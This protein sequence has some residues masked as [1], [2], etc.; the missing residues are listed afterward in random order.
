M[1]KKTERNIAII[2]ILTGL[3]LQIVT[4]ISGFIIPKIILK[5]FGSEANGLISSLNQILNF[6]TL[7][8]GGMTAVIIAKLYKPLKEEDNFKISQILVTAKKF[9]KKLGII[10]IIYSVIVGLIYSNIEK[11]IFS[12]SYIILLTIILSFN[13]LI[14]YMF[15]LALRNILYA[16]KKVYIISITQTI[17][18][19]FNMIFAVISIKIYPSI[20]ILKLVTGILYLI[21]P[22]VYYCYVCKNYKI[23]FNASDDKQL[24]QNRWDGFFVNTAHFIHTSTDLVVLT[25]FSD[26]ATVSVYS[27][28]M[29]VI[30]GMKNLIIAMT[31]GITPIIGQAYVKENIEELNRKFSIYED[32]MFFIV[33]I[34]FTVA[35]ILIT[36]FVLLYTR[37]ISDAN[38]NQPL[39]GYILLIT[40]TLYLLILPHINLAYSADKFK[41]MT[42]PSWIEAMINIF[43][44]I[45]AV[46]KFGIIGVA[47]GTLIAVVYRTIFQIKFTKNII[48]LRKAT[49]FYKKLFIYLMTSLIGILICINIF[50]IKQLNLLNWIE[51]GIIYTV[52]LTFIYVIMN[53]IFNKNYRNKIKLILEKRRNRK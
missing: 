29:L 5:Y 28:Y 46:I 26:L 47:M 20:H 39:L 52:I 23:D 51:K 27:I 13:L 30:S 22:I 17:I 50:P 45:F 12:R 16:D 2:N 14:Q 53:I 43:C 36:P 25:V 44:S 48:P 8:E 9:Y 19:I 42:N 49:Y 21:Q 34:L 24:I 35:G 33:F 32:G 3:M 41:E 6:I 40:E 31:N 38:Y 7:I 15:S 37:D 10:F 11:G 1:K 18:T 4:I